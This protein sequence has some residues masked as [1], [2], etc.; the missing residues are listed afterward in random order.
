VRASYAKSFKA[1]RVYDLHSERIPGGQSTVLDPR[2]GGEVA[3]AD[4]VFGGNPTL[5]PESGDS[6]S[7]GIAWSDARSQL[8]LG[9]TG[10]RINLD[11]R[12]VTFPS[13]QLIVDNETLFPQRVVR[14][15]DSGGGPGPITQV[16][17]SAVNLGELHVTGLDVDATYPWQTAAGTFTGTLRAT[18]VLQFDSRVAPSLSEQSWLGRSNSDAW[19]TRWRATAGVTWSRDAFSASFTSRYTGSYRDREPLTTGEF[20]EL[21]DFWIF[22]VNVRYQPRSFLGMSDA[23]LSVG[24]IDLFD[25][26]PQF[27][28]YSTGFDVYTNDIRGRIIYANLGLRWK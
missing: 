22:D 13:L 6:W 26:T 15:P 10:W 2:R 16:D 1:P 19:A 23:Y 27:A 7:A 12:I 11:Q 21:G 24:A 18:D 3:T 4:T 9:F 8:Q 28:N 14:A 5:E 25:H 17:F 20:L